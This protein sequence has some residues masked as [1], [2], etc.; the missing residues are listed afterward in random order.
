MECG[1]IRNY[2]IC[3]KANTNQNSCIKMK[4]PSTLSIIGKNI[5]LLPISELLNARTLGG[6][7][8]PFSEELEV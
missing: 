5:R 1:P 6:H 2:K 4:I 7:A 3:T 8:S